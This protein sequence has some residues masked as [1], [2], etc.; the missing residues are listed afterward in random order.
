MLTPVSDLIWI[1]SLMSACAGALAVTLL[2]GIL[3]W[4]RRPFPFLDGR[5]GSLMYQRPGNPRVVMTAEQLR[6]IPMIVCSDISFMSGSADDLLTA[7]HSKELETQR[8]RKTAGETR[9]MC[10]ICLESYSCGEKLRVSRS[11]IRSCY[12]IKCGVSVRGAKGPMFL[13][14]W[15]DGYCNI[16]QSSF[17]CNHFFHMLF[18]HSLHCTLDFKKSLQ[19]MYKINLETQISN[20]P[21]LF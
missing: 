4:T 9:R 8:G 2:A 18:T 5:R 15:T 6:K 17:P 21:L 10:C 1:S 14:C 16:G 19:L 7:L 12:Q 11:I 3:Y 13:V 20:L